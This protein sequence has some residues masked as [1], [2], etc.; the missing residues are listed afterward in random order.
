MDSHRQMA[1]HRGFS[2]TAMRYGMG[3]LV[4]IEVGLGRGAATTLVVD[5]DG[6]HH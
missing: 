5:G 6:I 4:E 3:V 2:G 1:G